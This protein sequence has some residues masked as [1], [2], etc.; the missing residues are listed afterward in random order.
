LAGDKLLGQF[1]RQL[2]CHE[3][4]FHFQFQLLFLCAFIVCGPRMIL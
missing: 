3:N 2:M 4:C 1:L